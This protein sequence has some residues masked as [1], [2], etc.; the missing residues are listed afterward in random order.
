[1]HADD[2]PARRALDDVRRRGDRPLA[3]VV[4]D[5]DQQEPAG[6]QPGP[7]RAQRAVDLRRIEQVGQR[8]VAR[9]H[10]VEGAVD[11]VEVAEVGK[12]ERGHGAEPSRFGARPVQRCRAD[13]RPEHSVPAQ[14]EADRLGPDPARAVKDVGRA[15]EGLADE[16]VEHVALLGDRVVPAV[17]VDEVV[18]GRQPVVE[19]ADRRAG[20]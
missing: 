9:Q 10:D 4:A 14:G 3:V 20:H 12:G 2:Q 16:P 19:V 11:A 7:H 6:P 1:V 13:V 8:V 17:A 18:V 15:A 5:A